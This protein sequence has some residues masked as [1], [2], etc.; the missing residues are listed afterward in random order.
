MPLGRHPRE[1]GDP[2]RGDDLAQDS[3]VLRE[4]GCWIPAFAGMTKNHLHRRPQFLALLF[5]GFAASFIV[6]GPSR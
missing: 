4:G 1:G 2:S 6:R 3:V 5:T